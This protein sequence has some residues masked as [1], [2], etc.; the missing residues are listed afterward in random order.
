MRRLALFNLLHPAS[1]F[2][3]FY[4][5]FL[6]LGPVF[7][8]FFPQDLPLEFTG[9]T[10]GVIL[11]YGICFLLAAMAVPVM[12]GMRPARMKPVI[13]R[14]G[15]EWLAAGLV[16]WGLGAAAMMVFYLK[17]GGVPALASDVET[18]RVTMKQ[19]LGRYILAGG[20]FFTIGLVY[21]HLLLTGRQQPSIFLRLLVWGLTG[22]AV[23]LMMGIGFRAPAAFMLVTV[24]LAR[25]ILSEGYQRNNRLQLRWVIFGVCLFVVLALV[26]YYRNTGQFALHVNIVIWPAIVH[27]GNLQTILSEFDN[28]GYFLGNSFVSDFM[29]AVPGVEGAFL[30]DYLKHLFDLDFRGGGMTVTA[31]GEGY[32][33]FGMPGVILHALLLGL[34]GG[35][36]YERLAGKADVQSRILLLLI[37]LNLARMVTSGIM[38]V[39]FFGFLPL[40]VAWW[41]GRRL[42]AFLSDIRSRRQPFR[43]EALPCSGA[44]G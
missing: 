16:L 25:V 30:G 36:A 17:A 4:L 34:V 39:L 43:E 15:S 38:P 35:F 6:V 26:G 18:A 3:A 19:G 44:R 27:A 31:P 11:L 8:L 28:T 24:V 21:L 2:M 33:N 13:L 10:L 37:S 12:L 41:I 22:V 7:L 9:R 5:V 20:G 23:I 1:F 42:L 40:L 29:A 32:V 14:V